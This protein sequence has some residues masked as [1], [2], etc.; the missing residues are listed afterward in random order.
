MHTISIYTSI[1]ILEKRRREKALESEGREYSE[2]KEEK[3]LFTFILY[4]KQSI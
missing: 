1:L 4:T 2:G 3:H